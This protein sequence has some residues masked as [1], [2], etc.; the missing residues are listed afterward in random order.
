M[1]QRVGVNVFLSHLIQQLLLCFTSFNNLH[2]C[3]SIN[4]LCKQHD[5]LC[6]CLNAFQW[7]NCHRDNA[8]CNYIVLQG[9]RRKLQVWEANWAPKMA[10]ISEW[11][12]LT[13]PHARIWGALWQNRASFSKWFQL[14]MA[15]DQVQLWW[16]CCLWA[17]LC[18]C[19]A[20]HWGEMNCQKNVALGSARMCV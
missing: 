13:K 3:Q 16:L 1:N 18:V 7:C 9:P 15:C 6:P 5:S 14:P 20:D 4:H 12:T 10:K 17:W 11:K 2:T 8:T 19:S